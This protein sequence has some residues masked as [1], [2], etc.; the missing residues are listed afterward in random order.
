M[1]QLLPLALHVAGALAYLHGRG[2]VH[3]DVKPDNIVMGVP[4]RLID[5]SIARTL[6]ARGPQQGTA[7]HR[8]VH[9]ARAVRGGSG[10]GSMGPPAD[11]WGLGATLHHALSG[12]GPS[13]GPRG[14]ERA[15]TR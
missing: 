9:G 15:R 10:H 3:L 1:Q 4:P 8:R 6:G 7:R 11:V 14:R 13:R 5:L 2:L 12:S